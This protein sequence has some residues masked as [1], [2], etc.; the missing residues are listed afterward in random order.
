M[1]PKLNLWVDVGGTFTDAILWSEPSSRKETSHR[2]LKVLSSGKIRCT[3]IS[4]PHSQKLRLIGLPHD[5]RNFWTT[6]QLSISISPYPTFT[7]RIVASDEDGFEID[8]EIPAYLPPSLPLPAELWGGLESPALAAHLLLDIPLAQKL[9]QINVRLGTTRG[10]NA[11][12]TRTGAAVGL[13]ITR[14]FG[15]IP[16]IG[17]QDRPEL[18]ALDVIKPAPLCEKILEVDE[19]ID[20]AGNILLPLSTAGLREAFATWK[21]TGIRSVAIVLMHSYRNSIHE[22]RVAEIAHEF[23][24]DEVICSSNTSPIRKLLSRCD[25]ALVDAYLSPILNDYLRTVQHQL[26]ITDT[27]GLQLMTS[28]GSLMGIAEFRG[29][30]S[31]LSGPAG[32]VVAVQE[33][34]QQIGKSSALAFDMGGTS[35]DVSRCTREELPIQYDTLKAG[36]RMVTPIL[37]IHTVAAGGGSIC[38]FDGVQLHVGPASAGS[39]PGPA[40]YGQ[41]GPLTITDINV[42]LGIIP[43]NALPFSIDRKAAQDRL[44]DVA[45]SVRKSQGVSLSD[46]EIATGFRQ[47]AN[48]TMADAIRVISTRQGADPREHVLVGFGGAAGQHQCDL[49]E[50]LEIPEIVDPPMAGLYSARGIGYARH[51][52]FA[53]IPLYQPLTNFSLNQYSQLCEKPLNDLAL[54][55]QSL[56]YDRKNLVMNVHYEMRYVG[57]DSTLRI[58]H[59]DHITKLATDFHEAHRLHYGYQQ[60]EHDIEICT[61]R[62]EAIGPSLSQHT[63]DYDSK[64]LTGPSPTPSQQVWF[65]GNWIACPVLERSQLLPDDTVVGPSIIVNSGHTTWIAPNWKAHVDELFNLRIRPTVQTNRSSTEIQHNAP[66]DSHVDPIFRDLMGQRLATIA[67]SMGEMLEKTAISVNIKERRD[68]SCA[69]FTADGYLIANAPHVPVHLGAMGQTVRELL[70]EFPVL[71]PQDCLITNDPNRGGSHL[72]DITVVT[73]VFD[74]VSMQIIFFVACRA[75]H[76]EIGGTTAGSMPPN[77]KSL[78]EEG[79]WIAPQYLVRRGES[80]IS[81]ILE[82]LTGARYP[83]RSPHENVA[84]LAAQQAA[85][86]FG[87]IELQRLLSRVGKERLRAAMNWILDASAARVQQWIASLPEQPLRFTDQLDDGSQL[88][89]TLTKQQLSDSTE[90]KLQ[91]DFHGTSTRHPGNFNANRAIVTAAL[92]YV[93]RLVAGDDL[94]L[95]EGALRPI[96]LFIPASLLSPLKPEQ[97][98]SLPPAQLPAVA[99]GN[100]ETSQRVVDVLLGALE[101]AAASQGT[102]NNFLFGDSNFG[103]Y[104]TICGGTGATANRNGC[105]AVQSHMTNTRITDPEVLEVRYPVRLM[106]FSIRR[107]SGGAGEMTGGNGVIRE[108]EFLKAVQVSIISSRRSGPPPYG[109]QGGKPGAWGANYWIRSSGIVQPLSGTCQLNLQA[110]DR[111]RIETPGGGGY[112]PPG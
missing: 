84:D 16:Y 73:P 85:N 93:I 66:R 103:Y 111:V 3:A 22:K 9:P 52:R 43:E 26:G 46:L 112:G 75:H 86:Q 106:E 62:L 82:Q 98:R 14:G 25:T 77:A 31:V 18:F 80:Q 95:N 4:Q 48:Q 37:S 24:F 74:P 104:E 10:T 50:T 83:S 79:V 38:S 97:A 89:V 101:V 87:V 65:Q 30:D 17:N 61:I 90:F 53:T 44:S 69:I 107:G 56:G 64:N 49:A 32:G 21:R 68:F 63:S 70:R 81:V 51:K 102:M 19:R 99:A 6:A 1:S 39:F 110:G 8:S 96:E 109:M 23:D 55:L 7:S 105:D 28:A 67:L 42:L 76:A 15:D 41:G 78:E 108:I 72:P 91:V 45:D 29:K 59:S 35:T 33:L 34:L 2:S 60:L 11:L 54:E 88:C 40:C 71:H 12:L 94:P 57:T 36:V 20:A 58:A 92:L 47:L 13:C 27:S 5:S 100:V